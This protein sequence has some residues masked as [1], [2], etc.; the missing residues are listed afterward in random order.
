MI[1]FSKELINQ[2]AMFE[3]MYFEKTSFRALYD[4]SNILVSVMMTKTS[5]MTKRLPTALSLTSMSIP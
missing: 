5:S 1:A 3:L 2:E 4:K